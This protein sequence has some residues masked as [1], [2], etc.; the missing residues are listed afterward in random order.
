MMERLGQTNKLANPDLLDK[1]DTVGIEME[2]TNNTEVLPEDAH[3]VEK[4]E[5]P[6]VMTESPREGDHTEVSQEDTQ[7]TDMP[8]VAH[9]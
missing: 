7:S 8:I 6:V 9:N 2:I 3:M 5:Q 1:F 4:P